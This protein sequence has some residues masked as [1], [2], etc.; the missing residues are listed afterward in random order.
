MSNNNPWKRMKR[1]IYRWFGY[2]TMYD[3]QLHYAQ[4][5]NPQKVIPIDLFCCM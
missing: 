5:R 4:K 1:C 3:T 2:R